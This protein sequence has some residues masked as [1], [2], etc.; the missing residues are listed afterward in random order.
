MTRT[1]VV[2]VSSAI[3]AATCAL[4]WCLFAYTP[5]RALLPGSLSGDLR[6]QYQDMAVRLDS[7]ETAA[8]QSSAW[9]ANI[10]AILRGEL[11]QPDTVAT[12]TVH[13]TDSILAASE[14]ERQFVRSYEQEE[15]F[16][17]S[18]LAPI[19]AEGMVFTS[20][21]SSPADVRGLASG[22][23]SVSSTRAIPVAAIYRGTIVALSVDDDGLSTIVVQHPND[24]ISVF[25]GLGNVFVSQGRKVAAG[26][27]LGDTSPRQAMRFELWHSG[28]ALNPREYIAF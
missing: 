17:L 3:A 11:P 22:G 20:P 8:R 25:A 26:E 21:L 10:S 28:S 4:I 23:V 7:I 9:S 12:A 1:R 19:A 13:I 18:V 6:A 27:R 24:F 2:I 14:A 5:L 15:R 16:N